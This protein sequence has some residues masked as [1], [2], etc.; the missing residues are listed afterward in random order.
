PAHAHVPIRSCVRNDAAEESLGNEGGDR[1]RAQRGHVRLGEG[2]DVNAVQIPARR[3][4]ELPGQLSARLAPG[5]PFLAPAPATGEGH[6]IA[7]DRQNRRRI[8]RLTGWA[9]DPEEIVRLVSLE[10]RAG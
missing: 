5:M 7:V 2:L 1:I 3:A 10:F 9:L 8:E 6:I 4:V